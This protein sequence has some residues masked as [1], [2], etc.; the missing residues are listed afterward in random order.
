M[1]MRDHQKLK[2]LKLYMSKLA[3]SILP[4]PLASRTR[5]LYD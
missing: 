1:F 3:I 5:N 2:N 4:N